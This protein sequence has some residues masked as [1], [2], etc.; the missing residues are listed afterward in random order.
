MTQP[1]GFVDSSY[2]HRALYGL[3]QAPCAWYLTFSTFLLS[4]GF[5]NSHCDSSLFIH[6]TPSF[7]TI[8]VVYVDDI[9]LTGS[10]PSH[11]HFLV[12]QM[13]IAF[14]IKELGNMSYFLGISVQAS[15]T[16]YFLSQ[17][18]YA[19]EIIH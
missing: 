19:Q 5:Y 14:S 3:K 16:H 9:L 12:T 18:K 4:Q 15:A 7:I 13:H 6:K 11:I 1:P 8:L 2:L 17:Q 10:D